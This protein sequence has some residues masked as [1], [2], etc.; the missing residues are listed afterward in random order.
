MADHARKLCFSSATRQLRYSFSAMRRLDMVTLALKRTN[1]VSSASSRA[2]ASLRE[3][4]ITT[5]CLQDRRPQ[6]RLL[7]HTHSHSHSHG[8]S[9]GHSHSH[10]YTATTATHHRCKRR[11]RTPCCSTRNKLPS[12][13]RFAVR[14]RPSCTSFAKHRTS[15][16]CCIRWTTRL[17]MVASRLDS[18]TAPFQAS[19][20]RWNRH[21]RQR[22]V[23]SCSHT[24]KQ[25]QTDR[26]ESGGGRMPA[27][28]KPLDAHPHAAGA[29]ARQPP[30]GAPCVTCGHTGATHGRWP[31]G[32]SLAAA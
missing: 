32:W 3:S 10:S 5:L 28:G 27:R 6:V 17:T 31:S 25:T 24:G 19:N 12:V 2:A 11:R 30:S 16:P 21:T 23:N 1:D 29:P 4:P 22:W 9:H 13:C 8:H 15:V 14:K 20:R 26:R 7:P 18:A